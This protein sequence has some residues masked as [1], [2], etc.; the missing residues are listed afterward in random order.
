MYVH[1]A[2]DLDLFTRDACERGQLTSLAHELYT[3]SLNDLVDAHGDPNTSYNDVSMR[4]S[5]SVC[6]RLGHDS[7]AGTGM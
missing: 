2:C 5:N 3:N 4:T 7:A 1:P 6:G